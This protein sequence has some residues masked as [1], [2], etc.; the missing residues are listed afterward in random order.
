MTL[1]ANNINGHLPLTYTDFTPLSVL[2][3]EYIAIAVQV[4]SPIKTGKE[5]VE[6]LRKSPT[7][8]SLALSSAAGGTHHMSFAMPLLSGE[9]TSRR[10][11]SSRSIHRA[12]RS[13]RCSAAMSTLFRGYRQRRPVRGQR[14]IARAGGEFAKRMVGPLSVAP[15]WPELGYKGVLENWR[16]V[17]GAKN[18]T[19]EQTAY[20]EN[21]FR[22]ITSSDEFRSYAEKNQWE[23]T[24][25]GAEDSRRFMA[26]QYDELK[27]VMTELGLAKKP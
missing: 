12:R 3:T 22:R 25:R 9:S 16:G 13:P 10:R 4:D 26:A 23:I 24:F 1:L 7:A 27:A 17:I 11:N 14:Q 21:V 8:L 2:L 19:A 6:I 5:L 20:W 15:T 18:I